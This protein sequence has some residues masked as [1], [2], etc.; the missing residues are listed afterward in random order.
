MRQLIQDG[1]T[2]KELL[3]EL[4]SWGWPRSERWF[5]QL[6]EE[7]LLR[8]G[9]AGSPQGKSGRPP[10]R[11]PKNTLRYLAL[12]SAVQ[13]QAGERGMHLG[14]L[15]A[16]PIAEWVFCREE[17]M[18]VTRQVVE[19]ALTSF[20]LWLAQV[21]EAE[22]RAELGQLPQQ[23]NVSSRVVIQGLLAIWLRQGQGIEQKKFIRRLRQ[24]FQMTE[25][26]ALLFQERMVNVARQF[27]IEPDR[28]HAA[29]Q[30]P[31]PPVAQRQRWTRNHQALKREVQWFHMISED[32]WE[33]I[34]V[35]ALVRLCFASPHQGQKD[36]GKWVIDLEANWWQAAGEVLFTAIAL[37]LG[38][39]PGGWEEVSRD[40]PRNT[41][42]L[43]ALTMSDSVVTRSM[44]PQEERDPQTVL[45]PVELRVLLEYEEAGNKGTEEWVV[46]IPGL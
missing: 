13:Q 33:L 19:N 9:E 7:G 39:Q 26:E 42:R 35:I 12:L 21:S 14:Q 37:V 43:Y 44:P 5:E 32:A 1:K 22:L 46:H 15:S 6:I 25:Q 11:W 40:L 16:L 23:G 36:T 20:L 3:A 4:A 30:K 24:A 18:E 8:P 38:T 28:S 2:K 45:P 10:D 29:T 41:R 34:R 31:R 27:H 17:E